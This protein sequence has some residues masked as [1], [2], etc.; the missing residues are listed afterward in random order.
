M[1]AQYNNSQFL[2]NGVPDTNGGSQHLIK[3]R[4][5]KKTTPL[6]DDADEH[7]LPDN[8]ER[9]IRLKATAFTMRILNME[10]KAD[11]RQQEFDRWLQ[12]IQLPQGV[13]KAESKSARAQIGGGHQ[14]G[15]Q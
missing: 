12:R 2:F 7:E 11:S 13:S 10:E 1:W 14:H 6:T 3:I 9:G 4:Y 15:T 8:W 5:W